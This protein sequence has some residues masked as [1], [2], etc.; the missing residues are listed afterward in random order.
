[1]LVLLVVRG[2]WGAMD[3]PPWQQQK[4]KPT[5]DVR[6]RRGTTCGT[7]RLS[8]LAKGKARGHVLVR[9]INNTARCERVSHNNKR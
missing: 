3:P 1:L 8:R 4:V 9:S 2:P 6:R 5:K 7:A